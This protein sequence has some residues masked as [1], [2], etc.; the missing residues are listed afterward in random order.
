MRLTIIICT[1]N[2]SELLARTLDHLNRAHYPRQDCQILVVANACHDDTLSLLYAY[3]EKMHIPL[4]FMEEPRPGKSHALNTGL[5]AV[6]SGIV[7]FVDDDHRVDTDYPLAV[8]E[9]FRTFPDTDLVC[10]RILPDWTG[11]EPAWVHEENFF[12]IY[13]LP[14]PRYDQGK[15]GRW[16]G[17]EGPLPGGGNLAIRKEVIDSVGGFSAELGPKGHDL[18]GSEDSEFVLRALKAGCRLR[19]TPEM[20]QYHYVDMERL[21]LGYIIHKAY[22]RSQ[23]VVR[24]RIQNG[25]DKEIRRL[26]PKYLYRKVAEHAWR[27]LF[28]LY[29][30][31]KR[32]YLV[33]TAASLGE[34]SAYWL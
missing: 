18:G 28:S 19:Y 30:P 10:G 17:T 23:T 1:H 15:E 26:P 21:R 25:S 22:K 13:P 3:Q 11:E 32:F 2:R 20:L 5:A 12:P 29:W 4:K 27:S 8:A 16:I 14:V 9:G 31:E 33:R 6:D 34:L 24:Y 7:A